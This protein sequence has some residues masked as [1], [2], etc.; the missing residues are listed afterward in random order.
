ME[1]M[2]MYFNKD[3]EK[4][5]ETYKQLIKDK[6]IKPFKIA[7]EEKDIWATHNNPKFCAKASV[8]CNLDSEIEWHLWSASYLFYDTIKEMQNYD[9]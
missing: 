2:Q 5:S 7:K 1:I 4:L 6:K 8:I 9:K 3:T